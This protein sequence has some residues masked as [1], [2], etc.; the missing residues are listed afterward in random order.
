MPPLLPRQSPQRVQL[1]DDQLVSGYTPAGAPQ[2]THPDGQKQGAVSQI[3]LMRARFRCPAVFAGAL[4][5]GLL[6]DQSSK[7][8]MLN[9]VMVPPRT[10][11]IFPFF[12]L[13]L[14][15]NP[16]ISFGMLADLAEIGPL[17][18]S[19]IAST[20]IVVLAVWAFRTK[21]TLEA[22]ALGLIAGG[23]LG[24]VTDRLRQGVVTD[25]LDFHIRDWH[26]P[27]FNLADVAITMGAACL[28]VGGLWP[29]P[30]GER[31]S[32]SAE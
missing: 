22:F 19:A 12:N 20:I 30:A 31:R 3:V 14:G 27:A 18:L 13:R 23:A 9:H 24:N 17:L 6:A 32:G 7:W 4:S 26:W 15:F 16:G 5:V 10:L 21:K 28:I 2:R 29:K 8:L 11:E 1:P 25:F